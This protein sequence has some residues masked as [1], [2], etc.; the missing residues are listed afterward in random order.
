MRQANIS[1]FQDTMRILDQ[2]CYTLNGK[3][4]RLK[5]TRQQM[6]AADVYLPDQIRLMSENKDFQHID[7]IGRCGYGCETADSFSLARKRREQL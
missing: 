7:I 1:M 4:V 3:T 5:L 6:E 2:G